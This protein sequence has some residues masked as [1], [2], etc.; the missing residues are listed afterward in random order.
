MCDF[1]KI[2]A[3]NFLRDLHFFNESVTVVKVH[4]DLIGSGLAKPTLLFAVHLIKVRQL[5]AGKTVQ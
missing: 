3:I 2:Y 1:W 4:S 5:V